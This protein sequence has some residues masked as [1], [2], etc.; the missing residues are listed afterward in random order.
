MIFFPSQ[1]EKL[2]NGS[3]SMRGIALSTVVV[4][5]LLGACSIPG[6]INDEILDLTN[7]RT[8]SPYGLAAS[9]GGL[10]LATPPVNTILIN[11]CKDELFMDGAKRPLCN[12][13]HQIRG[14][15]PPWER[16]AAEARLMA[17]QP[18]ELQ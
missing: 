2:P 5:L 18:G 15:T 4:S 13:N 16:N 1:L 8:K 7:N 3:Q 9:A 12:L 17:Y 11:S 10:M 6:K 14:T